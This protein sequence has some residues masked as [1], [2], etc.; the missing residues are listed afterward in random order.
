MLVSQVFFSG[1]WAQDLHYGVGLSF[2]IAEMQLW[3]GL[4]GSL[5]QIKKERSVCSEQ[6]ADMSRR[7]YDY[8]NKDIFGTE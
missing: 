8:S 1:I 5:W 7:I 4:R 2:F 6:H 3:F